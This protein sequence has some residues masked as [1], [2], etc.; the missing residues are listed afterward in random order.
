MPSIP[1]TPVPAEKGVSTF[2]STSLMMGGAVP[3]IDM[4][5]HSYCSGVVEYGILMLLLEGT[6][7]RVATLLALQLIP[8]G[9][10]LE[11]LALLVGSVARRLNPKRWRKAR[12]NEQQRQQMGGA[13]GAQRAAQAGQGSPISV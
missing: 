9:L 8:R 11:P 1:S 2:D 13:S 7:F 4:D 10:T 6:A 5:V 12:R 3:V